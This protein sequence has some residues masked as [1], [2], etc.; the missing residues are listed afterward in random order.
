MIRKCISLCLVVAVSAFLLAG[1]SSKETVDPYAQVTL[2][3]ATYGP[4]VISKGYKYKIVEPEIIEAVGHLCFVREG[5][6]TSLI[7]GRSIADKIE[8]MEKGTVSF[9]VVKEFSPYVHFRAEQVYSGADTVFISAAG[10]IFYPTLAKA[11]E[12]RAKDYDDINWRN[13]EFNKS[14][15]LKKVV[16]EKFEVTGKISQVDEDGDM[17]WM[18]E[19]ERGVKF[20]VDNV[21]DT[22]LLALRMLETTSADGVVDFK[23]G[24]TFTEIEDWGDRQSNKISGTVTVEYVQF[25]DR[26]F[27]I[28]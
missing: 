12:F 8:S 21:E 9:N 20:R 6:V 7:S 3:Q 11:D 5:G 19:G 1:C 24:V 18:I 4:A 22:I 13:V 2:R 17:V 28:L 16:D 10:S 25:G 27:S 15:N 23:G 14:A 26:V